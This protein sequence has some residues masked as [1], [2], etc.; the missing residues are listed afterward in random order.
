MSTFCDYFDN[1][2]LAKHVESMFNIYFPL[3]MQ[4]PI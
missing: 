1:I 3:Q 2:H 4:V